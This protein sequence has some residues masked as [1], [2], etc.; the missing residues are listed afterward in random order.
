MQNYPNRDVCVPS[1]CQTTVNYLLKYCLERTPKNVP[2]Q[3]M[4]DD[5]SVIHS[6]VHI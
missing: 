4:K 6:E 2:V 3:Y 5:F 1:V